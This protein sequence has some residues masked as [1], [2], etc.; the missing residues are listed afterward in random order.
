V[1]STLLIPLLLLTFSVT[2]ETSPKNSATVSQPKPV[3]LLQTG[4]KARPEFFIRNIYPCPLEVAID[5]GKHD[6][7]SAEPDLPNRF[8]VASG[9]SSAL[10]KVT[11]DQPRKSTQFSLSYRYIFGRPLTNYQSTYLYQPP[12]APKTKFRISQ[13]F[14]GKFSHTDA[15]NR[16]AVDISMPLD[17]PVYAARAGIVIDVKDS[18]SDHGKQTELA[19]KANSIRILHDDSSMAVYAHLA[20]DKAQVKAG[21]SVAAGQLIAY[22]G[23]T[24]YSSGP[25]LHFAVQ[26]NQGMELVS[27]PFEFGDAGQKGVEPKFGE[28]LVG[29]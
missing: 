16:Y 5:W 24:G 7:V 27:V 23:N 19:S 20:L 6:N 29:Y 28:W 10:F 1:R 15:Q 13:A 22:S 17:T 3:L 8:V 14:D 4:D 26:I 21:M 9:D 11:P 12:I 18:Y 25:H 2:A